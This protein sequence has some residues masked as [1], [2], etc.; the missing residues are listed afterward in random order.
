MGYSPLGPK[1]LDMIEHKRRSLRTSSPKESVFFQVIIVIAVQ[2]L[3]R[4]QPS[5]TWWAL[6]P[7]F[8][9]PSI[10]ASIKVFSN[11]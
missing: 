6:P 1:E 9:L 10:L 3:S 11:E 5:A 4:V 7:L 2:L 8:L